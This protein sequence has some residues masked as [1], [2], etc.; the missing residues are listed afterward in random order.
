MTRFEGR[1]EIA[2]EVVR[3]I[4]ALAATEA[5]GPQ[6]TRVELFGGQNKGVDVH[7][8]SDS[9]RIT[10][11]IAARYGHPLPELGRRLQH[12]VREEVEKLTGLR[13]SKVDVHVQR[14][15]LPHEQEGEEGS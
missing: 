3:C 2:E 12:K 9:V 10:L 4:A 7:W 15:H 1:V 13:V 8:E 11:R 6:G 5:E 14:L